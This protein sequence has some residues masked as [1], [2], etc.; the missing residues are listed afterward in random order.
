MHSSALDMPWYQNLMLHILTL[1]LLS[2]L[3]IIAL[4]TQKVMYFFFDAKNGRS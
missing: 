4:I 2:G 3:T 1:V